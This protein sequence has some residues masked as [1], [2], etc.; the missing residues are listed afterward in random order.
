M[1]ARATPSRMWLDWHCSGLTSNVVEGARSIYKSIYCGIYPLHGA[2]RV[3]TLVARNRSK[4]NHVF[5]HSRFLIVSHGGDPYDDAAKPSSRYPA[6]LGRCLGNA[7]RFF[8]KLCLY[9]SER[10]TC[11]LAFR[12]MLTFVPCQTTTAMAHLSSGGKTSRANSVLC[13]A[14]G[15]LAAPIPVRGH[16]SAR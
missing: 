3:A 5:V 8:V 10:C 7:A 15:L 16:I 2:R 9:L 12:L 11:L 1:R 13:E 4:E 14:R 6:F